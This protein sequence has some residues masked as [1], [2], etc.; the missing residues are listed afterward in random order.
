MKT[1]LYTIALCLVTFV[2]SAQ[3]TPRPFYY[4]KGAKQYLILDTTSLFTEP[5]TRSNLTSGQ[6]WTKIKLNKNDLK[7]GYKAKISE[8]TQPRAIAPCYLNEK[9]K[10]FGLSP[11]LYVKIKQL[12]DSTLLKEQ[13]KS[14]LVSIVRQNSFNPLWYLLRCIANTEGNTMEIANNF[15]ESGLF[16]AAEPDFIMEDLISGIITDPYYTDQWNLSNLGQFG[17]TTFLDIDAYRAWQLS[18]GANIVVAVVDQGVQLNHPDLQ[19]NIYP[20]SY[21]AYRHTSP[22]TVWEKH[23]TTC[24]GI[25]GAVNNSN[26]IIGVAPNCKLM[27]VSHPINGVSHANFDLAE[28]ID[29][30][31]KNGADILSCSWGGGM[32]TQ[33]LDESILQA[34]TKGRNGKGCIIAFASGNKN[35]SSIIYPANLNTVIAVGAMTPWGERKSPSSSDGEKNWGSN[36]GADLD[37]VAPGVLIPTTDRTGEEGYNSQ[38]PLHPKNGG[39][40]ITSDYSNQGYTIW[41][42]GTSA[43]CPH[44]AAIAALILAIKP[45]LSQAEVRSIIQESCVKLPRYGYTN[46][47]AHPDGSW[48]QEVGHGLVNAYNALILTTKNFQIEGL[49]SAHQKATY[50]LN[51]CPPGATVQWKTLR[52]TATITSQKNGSATFLFHP[53]GAGETDQIQATVTYKGKSYPLSPLSIWVGNVP[54]VESVD[55]FTYSGVTGEYTLKAN[56]TDPNVTCTWGVQGAPPNS[57][58]IYDIPYPGDATF[59]E[60]PQ[61]FKEIEFY[62]PANYTITVSAT[63]R[64]GTSELFTFEKWIHE[65]KPRNHFSL[66]PNPASGFVSLRVNENKSPQPSSLSLPQSEMYQIQLWSQTGLIRTLASDQK[67]VRIDLGG[68]QPGLYF[69][70]VIKDGQTFKEKLQVQ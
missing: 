35:E 56:V 40:K 42:N 58:S 38:E 48:N 46:T 41:F 4:Y 24:A 22:S 17:N 26:G 70:H 69:I 54:V 13:A 59:A 11:Y 23:G 3:Q 33:I 65:I 28:G 29:W 63:N 53:N 57:Y 55:M 20:A 60:C 1:Y 47:L 68:L 10:S 6:R 52:N 66:Y 25:I 14:H 37:V 2:V 43:A 49:T 67:E 64:Y 32:P 34:T 9:G 8:A 51:F 44:V 12:S 7:G 27:S 19:G 18:R 36:Y 31:W 50:S 45:E 61:L 15:Y 39:N 30:A 16:E 5:S 21:D 62:T